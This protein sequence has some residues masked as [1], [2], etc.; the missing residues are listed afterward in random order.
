[1]ASPRKSKARPAQAPRPLVPE[2]RRAAEPGI[3]AAP[4]PRKRATA[5]APLVA[6]EPAA[7]ETAAPAPAVANALDRPFPLTLE[8]DFLE[9]L[10][11]R[12][13]DG[14]AKSVSAVIRQALEEFDSALVPLAPPAPVT[15]SVRLPAPV[16]ESL[17]ELARLRQT[18]IGQLVRLAVE[19]HLR[20]RS[21]G[22]TARPKR[23]ARAPLPTAVAPTPQRSTAAPAPRKSVPAAAAPRDRP[24]PPAKRKPPPAPK[25]RRR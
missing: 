3:E 21:S 8:A 4:A 24:N 1:M 6:A 14:H 15:I 10:T 17:R 23:P 22:G 19:D 25:P 16:R 9:R 5:A 11:E 7:G 13:E 2:V 20:R 18:S 12:V